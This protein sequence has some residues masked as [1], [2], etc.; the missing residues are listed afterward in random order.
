MTPFPSMLGMMLFSL[1]I[2]FYSVERRIVILLVSFTKSKIV[3]LF[4]NFFI[5]VKTLKRLSLG[6][7]LYVLQPPSKLVEMLLSG[8]DFGLYT[9]NELLRPL[10]YVAEKEV[11]NGVVL[12]NLLTK[13]LIFLDGIRHLNDFA[14]LKADEISQLVRKLFLVS[15]DFNEY[16]L[17]NQIRDIGR[18][19]QKKKEFIRNYTILTTTNCNARCFYCCENGLASSSMYE[20]TADLVA[21]FITDT[22][23]PD[24]VHLIWFGGEPLLNKR[25]I[26]RITTALTENKILFRSSMVTNGYLFDEETIQEAIESWRLEEVQITL[27]GTEHIY[28]QRKSFKYSNVNAFQT[29]IEN[30]NTLLDCHVKVTIRMNFDGENIDDIKDLSTLLYNRFAKKK[31]FSAYSFPL[32]QSDTPELI[33]KWKSLEPIIMDQIG[34]S[35]VP[36]NMDIIHF[37]CMA[38]DG[39]SIIIMPDGRLC[40]CEFICESSVVGDVLSGITKDNVIEAWKERLPEED[41]CLRCPFYPNCAQLRLCPLSSKGCNPSYREGNLMQLSFA[42]GDFWLKNRYPS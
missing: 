16:K 5:F 1:L 14:Y 8:R 11:E 36:L 38:D 28:N 9:G 2:D 10:Y 39:E 40:L 35:D 4:I 31:G 19:T 24:G 41:A 29:V 6:Y 33:R 23:N 18:E 21:R 25:V 20:D 15:P 32:Y 13:E 37:S 26:R 30:I 3:I 17:A 22:G 12:F 34:Q 27:D 7:M 42:I